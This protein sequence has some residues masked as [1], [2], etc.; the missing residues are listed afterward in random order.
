MKVKEIIAFVKYPS[1][2]T[3]NEETENTFLK[4]YL[5]AFVR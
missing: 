1:S 2:A 5:L 3:L 4:K